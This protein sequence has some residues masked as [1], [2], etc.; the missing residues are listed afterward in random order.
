MFRKNISFPFVIIA[1]FLIGLLSSVEKVS[2]DIIVES[3]TQTSSIAATTGTP[4]RYWINV[5][6]NTGN[7][8]P[9]TK[10][11]TKRIWNRMYRGYLTRTNR[12]DMSGWVV[13]EGYLY[14]DDQYPL[15][16][17]SRQSVK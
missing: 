7:N 14:R 1:F 2:A 12:T 13:Y 16:I 11:Y 8:P 4:T 15:P 9:A 17:P 3:Y 10:F 5:P 6:F